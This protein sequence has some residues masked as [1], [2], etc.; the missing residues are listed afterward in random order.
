MQ[1][2]R[3]HLAMEILRREAKCTKFWKTAFIVTFAVVIINRIIGKDGK[4]E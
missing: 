3:P 4:T 1:T 2:N